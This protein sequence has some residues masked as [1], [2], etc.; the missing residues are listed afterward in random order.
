MRL[1]SPRI[2]EEV[3]IRQIES[4][5]LEDERPRYEGLNLWE[6]ANKEKSLS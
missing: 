2:R 4:D 5:E 6:G 1:R 3:V